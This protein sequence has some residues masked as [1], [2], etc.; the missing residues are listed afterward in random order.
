M[1]IGTFEHDMQRRTELLLGKDNLM[2][3]QST[4]VII[5]GVGGV[6]SWCVEGLLRSGVRNI[7]IVDSDCVCE[8]NCNRQLMATS[9]TVGRVKVDAL[10]DRLLEINPTAN[11]V[12]IQKVYSPETA[13][14][15]H[16]E[17]YDF[18]VDAIDSLKDKADLILRAT[19]LPDH[20]TFFSSMGAA[21]RTNPFM[22]SQAEFYKVHGDPLAR[23]LRKKFKHMKVKPVRKFQ[24]VFSEEKPLENLGD[25]Q[26]LT[27]DEISSTK[28]QINGSLCH[29]TAT[30]GMALAGMIINTCLGTKG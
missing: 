12:A 17:Q 18:I 9:H 22:V 16:L 21:L 5:F 28:A 3:L 26:R 24:C 19:S 14:E 10:K 11:I 4:K 20:I 13:E 7:T 6:G 29:I 25:N 15:F 23:A 1:S 8:T 27:P 30:F 2:K